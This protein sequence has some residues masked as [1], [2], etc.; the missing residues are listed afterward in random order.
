MNA[1]DRRE[2]NVVRP[3]DLRVPIIAIAG[4]SEEGP[5][6]GPKRRITQ[7]A[8]VLGSV[9]LTFNDFK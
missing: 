1:F 9:D 5:K 7:L 4:L 2:T 3:A 8:A 6:T